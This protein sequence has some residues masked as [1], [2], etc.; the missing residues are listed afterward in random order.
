MTSATPK[1]PMIA[2][3]RPTPSLNSR[4]PKV[5]RWVPEMLSMPIVLISRPKT[6]IIRAFSMEPARE[7]DEDHH[8]QEHQAKYSGG[9]KARANLA[10][11]G[12]TSIRPMIEIVPAMKEPKA[13]MPRA[14]PARPFRAIW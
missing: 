12:A 4:M 3:I 11:G 7:V 10:R 13:A 1:S 8:A 9:P 6:A 14:G 5:S 2:G